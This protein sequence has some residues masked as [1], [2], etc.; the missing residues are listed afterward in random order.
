MLAME[1]SGQKAVPEP[2]QPR[3][4]AGTQQQLEVSIWHVGKLNNMLTLSSCKQLTT[5]QTYTFYSRKHWFQDLVA[6]CI[7][8]FD[9]ITNMLWKPQ[10]SCYLPLE[11][12]PFAF[13]IESSPAEIHVKDDKQTPNGWVQLLLCFRRQW[14]L[15]LLPVSQSTAAYLKLLG[16]LSKQLTA[17]YPR[18]ETHLVPLYG[19]S[20]VC[21]A[22]G[23]SLLF[24]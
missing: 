14:G 23:E 6:S 5:L 17:D 1:S 12:G 19:T 7:C 21:R 13:F 24:S 18:Q 9:A 4:R 10:S 11:M 15:L 22:T 16:L 2:Q 20:A 8:C 3:K